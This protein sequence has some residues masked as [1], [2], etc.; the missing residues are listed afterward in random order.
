MAALAA[1]IGS[2]NMVT[3]FADETASGETKYGWESDAKNNW[4]YYDKDGNLASELEGEFAELGGWEAESDASKL[5]QGLGLDESIMYAQMSSLAGNEKV[6]V[7]LAQALFG[8]PDILLL[9]EPTVGVDP[10]SRR[11]LWEILQLLVKEEHLSVFVNTAYMDEAEL[12]QQ[13]YVINHGQL[14][15]HGKP[16]DICAVA[17]ERCYYMEPYAGTPAR[18]L[19]SILLDDKQHVVDSVP[20]GHHVRFIRQANT[21]IEY[22]KKKFGLQ[23]Q[24]AKE[25]LEDGFMILLHDDHSERKDEIEIFRLFFLTFDK[26]HDNI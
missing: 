14:L 12:C 18:I 21:D 19:Q 5:V 3:A 11:E 7:L 10:L 15:K 20:E 26:K 1:A 16:Q 25:R 2:V 4:R 22:F 24:A 23:V 8:N 9:D 13:V 17:K 6:K